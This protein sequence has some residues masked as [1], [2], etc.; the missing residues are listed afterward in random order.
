MRPVTFFTAG[1]GLVAAADAVIFA[2]EA[3]FSPG[4]AV[5]LGFVAGGSVAIVLLASLTG[6]RA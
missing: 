6:G 4:C 2:R 1:S 5:T 3:G